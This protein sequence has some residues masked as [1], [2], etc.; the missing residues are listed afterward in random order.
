ML[1]RQ[2]QVR[3]VTLAAG[4]VTWGVVAGPA[5]AL[6][7]SCG[8][9]AVANTNNVLC[10]APSGPC[11]AT[12]VTMGA[13]IDVTSGGCDFDLGNRALTVSKTLQMTALGFIKIRNA[14]SITV[15]ST[16]KLKARGDFVEPNGYIVPGG[17]VSLDS[18]GAINIAGIIDVSGDPGGSVHV[19]GAAGVT[20]QS[21][22][23]VQSNGTTSFVLDGNR[24]SDGGQ[25]DIE[26]AAG[27]ITINDA[28][29]TTGTRHG[30]GGVVVLQAART[31]GIAGTIDAHGGESDGGDVVVV[32]G[33]DI[34][35]GKTITVES[36]GGGGAG[37]RIDLTAG[38]DALGGIATGGGV[39]VLGS[40]LK[41]SGSS[42]S[43][44]AGDG[45]ALFITASGPVRLT[46]TGVGIHASSGATGDGFG[47]TVV[48][49]TTDGDDS[50][51]GALDGDISIDGIIVAQGGST[52]G[53]GGDIALFA[54]KSLTLNASVN[55]T[56][57]DDGGTF[58]GAAGGAVALNGAISAQASDAAG[59]GGSVDVRGGFAQNATLSVTKDILVASGANST[60]AQSIFLSSCALTVG[61]SVKLDGRAGT[62]GGA[63][64][65]LV[66]R[67]PMQLNG[68]SQ[69]LAGPGGTIQTI[70]PPGQNPVIGAGAVFSPARTDVPT[71]T[72]PFQ[73]CAQ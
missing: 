2:I 25:I 7:R 57:E 69:Y 33:D 21:G 42:L 31:V 40:D 72:F 70:H 9:D 58:L 10:A 36:S 6:T 73:P 30:A 13:S 20:L 52:G 11:N 38:V 67:Q 45:G 65:Q 71:T 63:S 62:S 44:G 68:T 37:G 23:L 66:A 5:W 53:D 32:A 51:I 12:S 19:F 61:S 46:G 4:V 39:T 3:L 64:I 22:S 54:G 55:V 50:T 27:A 24:Y 18:V 34:T 8:P 43:G 16:G 49:D 60:A 41:L 26:S 28:I 1:R 56:G 14:A 35:I 15:T 59:L 29:S 47:G 17:S 48:I